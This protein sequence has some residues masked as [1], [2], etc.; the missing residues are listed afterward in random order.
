MDVTE[1]STAFVKQK[2]TGTF[3]TFFLLLLHVYND[4]THHYGY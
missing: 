4:L 2:D 3:Y 1:I